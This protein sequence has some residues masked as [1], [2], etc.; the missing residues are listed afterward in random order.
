MHEVCEH[1]TNAR[2]G[3]VTSC[4]SPSVPEGL[5]TMRLSR[6]FSTQVCRWRA[7]Y[8]RMRTISCC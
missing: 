8:R 3:A 7:S 5:K 4:G 2:N 1:G 6:N